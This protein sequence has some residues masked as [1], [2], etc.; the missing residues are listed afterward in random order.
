MVAE[1]D[2]SLGALQNHFRNL[3]VPL[4]VFIKS[5]RIYLAL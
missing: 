5:G 1:F 3:R 4:C 2:Q